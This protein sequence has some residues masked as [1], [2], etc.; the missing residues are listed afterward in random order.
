MRLRIHALSDHL[1]GNV[2]RQ[3]GDLAFG[4]IHR[5]F[6]ITGN[7]VLGL[8]ADGIRLL[9][10]LAEDLFL[11]ALTPGNRILYNLV[12][13]LLRLGQLLLILTSQ[14]RRLIPILACAF[15]KVIDLLLPTCDHVHNRLPKKFLQ[16][17]KQDQR[18]DQCE[19]GGEKI[20]I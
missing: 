3:T 2:Q 10:G 17:Q 20:D 8:T 1:T 18:I 6:L 4:L 16:H 11:P 15:V 9:I 19:Q 13:G 5:F 14:L 7:I 12:S